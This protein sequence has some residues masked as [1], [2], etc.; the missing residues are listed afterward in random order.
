MDIRRLKNYFSRSLDNIGSSDIGIYED[1][2]D[3]AL[4]GFAIIMH[5]A[6]NMQNFLLMVLF[7]KE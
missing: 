2:I 5:F 4:P 7:G 3:G 1:I 6:Q